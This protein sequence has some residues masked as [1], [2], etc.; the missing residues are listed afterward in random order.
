MQGVISAT[1]WGFGFVI[2]GI[3]G[4]LLNQAFGADALFFIATA[5]AFGGVV[6]GLFG[7]V[8]CSAAPKEELWRSAPVASWRKARRS[9]DAPSIQ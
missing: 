7:L 5:V 8:W 6:F 4:G 2:G 3:G 1:F 9:Y